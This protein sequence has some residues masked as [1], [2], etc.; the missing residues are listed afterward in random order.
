[1]GHFRPESFRKQCK[2]LGGCGPSGEAFGPYAQGRSA[3]EPGPVTP[4]APGALCRSR[5]SRASLRAA[6]CRHEQSFASAEGAW[7][8]VSGF[9]GS[10][11]FRK[12]LSV[13]AGL[14]FWAA[15][16]RAAGAALPSR[17]AAAFSVF[18]CL[19]RSGRRPRRR[20]AVCP[21]ARGWGFSGCASRRLA[22]KG[23]ADRTR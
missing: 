20:A 11:R 1:M 19:F 3:K 23:P 7:G 22:G 14:R 12:G 17:W 8:T 16:A 6:F 2:A 9:R 18:R 13:D 10:R 15:S 4:A 5:P 21:P